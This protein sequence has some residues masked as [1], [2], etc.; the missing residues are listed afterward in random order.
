MRVADALIA[1]G[2]AKDQEDMLYVEPINGFYG[3]ADGVSAPYSPGTG[4]VKRYGGATG[5]QL[6]VAALARTLLLPQP[7]ERLEQ[8]LFE[9]NSVLRQHE[10]WV[11]DAGRIPAASLAL[12]EVQEGNVHIVTAG[13]AFAVWQ[14][15]DG[16]IRA[17]PN[18][19]FEYELLNRQNFGRCLAASGG[20]DTK[21]RDAHLPFV[22][23]HSRKH[24]N[25]DFAEFNGQQA[26]HRLCIRID[27]SPAEL[28]LLMLFTDGLV[29]FEWTKYPEELAPRVILPYEEGGLRRI[30]ADAHGYEHANEGK[31][32]EAT[33]IALEF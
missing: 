28:H 13:D 6:V 3:V 27:I 33:A 29:N 30:L 22:R 4:G 14:M 15:K 7:G 5:G 2:T 31:H 20:D 23:D 8:I 21:A 16:T 12:A 17:T 11:D 19:T 1:Q 32:P 25:V 18:P 10:D 26:F 9:A 24:K